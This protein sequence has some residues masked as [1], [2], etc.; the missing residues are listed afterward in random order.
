MI[1]VAQVL[2]KDEYSLITI[3]GQP[4]SVEFPTEYI[5]E[6]HRRFPGLIKYLVHTHPVGITDMSEEDRTTLKAWTIALSPHPVALDVIAETTDGN[7]SYKRYY[8]ILEPLDSWLARDK[9]SPRVFQLVEEKPKV[10][11]F[12]NEIIK[13]SKMEGGEK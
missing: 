13:L 3:F 4:G 11:L 10:K 6:T 9:Q 12:D 8:Y 1:E 5:W 2:T 7:F